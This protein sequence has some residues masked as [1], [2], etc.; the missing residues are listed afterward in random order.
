[1]I[2]ALLAGIDYVLGP[3]V[4]QSFRL[5]LFSTEYRRK[6]H[7]EVG[8]RAGWVFVYQC[9]LLAFLFGLAVLIFQTRRG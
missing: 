2:E 8:G 3:A 7:A 1:M 4:S 6:R 5:Y 9:A